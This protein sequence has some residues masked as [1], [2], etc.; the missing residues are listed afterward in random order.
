[1]EECLR[2][3]LHVGFFISWFGPIITISKEEPSC[4]P[5]TSARAVSVPVPSDGERVLTVDELARQFSV[6]KK[7]VFRWRRRGLIGRPFLL[8]GSR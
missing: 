5:I 7:T 6:S 8:G 4:S 2:A 1:M 3:F